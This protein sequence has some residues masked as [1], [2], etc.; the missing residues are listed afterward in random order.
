MEETDMSNLQGS[1]TF[2]A[3]PRQPGRWGRV[4][5]RA[6]LAMFLLAQSSGCLLAIGAGGGVGGAVYVMGKLK[7]DVQAPVAR[8]HA[9]AR[10]AI[11]DLGIPV[12]QDKGDSLTAHLE[13]EFSDGKRVWIDVEKS[14]DTIST[15]TIRVGLM[16]D[17]IRSR[18]ILAKIRRHL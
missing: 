12:I 2:C 15:L 11:T 18:E 6:V 5:G 3:T 17:E 1:R 4:V 10:A 8:V 9:A 16:G 14:S 7:E 13:S